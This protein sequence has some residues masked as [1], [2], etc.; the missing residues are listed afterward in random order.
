MVPGTVTLYLPYRIL[1]SE[2][3]HLPTPVA[4]HGLPSGIGWLAGMLIY[5]RCVRDF[6]IEGLGTPAPLDPPKQLVANGLYR[7]S[8][9][10]MY[11]GVLLMLVSE[12]VLFGQMALL[13]YAATVGIV[14]QMMVMFYEEPLL[15]A[16]FGE[17]Y[18][19]YCRQ[20]PRWIQL[21]RRSN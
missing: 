3:G 6:A 20:V 15:R 9:N 8:R 2:V 11:L 1:I 19:D 21:G 5:L 13:L 12:S 16:R 14:L 10:P 4:W 7:Y 18:R 17:S